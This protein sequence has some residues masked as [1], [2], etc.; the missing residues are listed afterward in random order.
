MRAILDWFTPAKRKAIYAFVVVAA[1]ALTAFGVITQEQL[2][3]WV[4][5]ASGVIAALAALLALINVN[6]E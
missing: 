5:N 4:Q 3:T 6:P 1:G 2:D